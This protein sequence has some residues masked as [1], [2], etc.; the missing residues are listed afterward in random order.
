MGSSMQDTKPKMTRVLALHG[1]GTSGEIFRSQTAA[2]RLKLPKNSY[3]FTFPNAPL[4]SAP[5]VG[6]DSIWNQTP[7]ILRLVACPIV[8]HF[9]NPLR[10]RP[11]RPTPI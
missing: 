1:Y 6:V 4:P 3:T 9:G 7:Q 2:F 8:Q 10:A 11:T 5:T